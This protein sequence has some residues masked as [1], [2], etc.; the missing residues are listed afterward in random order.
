MRTSNLYSLLGLASLASAQSANVTGLTALLA[1]TPQLSNLT[2]FVTQF[3]ALAAQ[4]SNATNITILAPSNAAFAK[5]L[6]GGGASALA[7]T[8]LVQSLLSYHVLAGTYRA[9]AITNSSAFVPTLLTNPRYA[10]VTG[11]QRV[12]VKKVGSTVEI[13][14]GLK[15]VSNVTTADQNFTGGVVHIIDTV[16]TPPL[17]VSSTAVAFNLTAAAGALTSARLVNTVDTAR[18]LT[19][20][21]PNNAAFQRIGSALPN[22]TVEQITSILTYHVVNGTVGYS[23]TLRDNAKL[24]TLNGGQLTV[25]IQNGSV[26][27]NSAKVVVADV[28]VANGVVHVIDNVLN[29]GNATATPNPSVSTQ[30][31]AFAGASSATNVPYTSGVPTPTASVGGAA[32][33]TSRASAASTAPATTGAAA[34]ARSAAVGMGALF[35]GAAIALAL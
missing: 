10:N 25:R 12:E 16:L 18:D 13:I 26:F 15:S 11:G 22:L 4:L 1:A 17:N 3:P 14:S 7:D 6:A 8:T 21:V 33:T 20:F 27:V 2:T 5:L 34:P 31:P 23:S 24:T 9:A 28:L 19:I 32:T 35:G 29:P 30:V